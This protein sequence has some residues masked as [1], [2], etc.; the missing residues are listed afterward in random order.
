MQSDFHL[1]YL[2][3][4]A[5]LCLINRTFFDSYQL[6]DKFLT[7]SSHSDTKLFLQMSKSYHK[8]IVDPRSVAIHYESLTRK[9]KILLDD[10]ESL[11]KT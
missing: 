8:A 2:S 1:Q 11:I 5:A 7:P 4:T 6:F 10:Y 3:V 9:Q